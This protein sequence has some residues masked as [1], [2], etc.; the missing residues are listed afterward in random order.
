MRY[1]LDAT[2][3]ID[4]LRGEAAAAAKM[5]SMFESADELLVNEVAVCEAATGARP[6]DHALAALLEPLEF[7]Q[8][9]P[10]AAQLAARWRFE[11]RVRG[12]TLALPDAL[13]AAAA[14]DTDAVVLTRNLRDFALTP[15][16]LEAY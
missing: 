10:L 8:P 9:G 15:A 7:I 5:R 2:F 3:L 14:Y 1:L 13:I 6:G 16:R 12:S 11:A 4:Y